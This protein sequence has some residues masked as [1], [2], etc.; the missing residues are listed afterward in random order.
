MDFFLYAFGWGWVA[1]LNSLLSMRARETERKMER[2]RER[3]REER[4]RE[5]RER[6]RYRERDMN[7][8]IC[9]SRNMGS[10]FGVPAIRTIILWG[11]YIGSQYVCRLPHRARKKMSVSYPSCCASSSEPCPEICGRVGIL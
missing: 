1:S 6:E 10:L 9:V 3:E 7:T 2:E 5:E 11:L 4:E 8:H